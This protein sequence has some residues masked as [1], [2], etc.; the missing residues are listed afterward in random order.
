MNYRES[1]LIL[2]KIKKAER[3][4]VN[5]H[6]SPDPDSVGSALSLY[7]ALKKMDKEVEVVCPDALASELLFLPNSKLVKQVNFEKFDYTPFDL[8]IVLD[9]G[10]WDMVTKVREIPLPEIDLIVIDH[11]KTNTRFGKLNL[12]DSEKGSVAE[13]LYLVFED[14][15]ILIDKNIATTLLAGILGDTVV[16]KYAT[17]QALKITAD[18]IAKGAPKDEII[19]NLFSSRDFAELKLWGEFLQKMQIDKEHKFIWSAVDSEIAGNYPKL[20]GN[21]TAATLFGQLVKDIN[22]SIFMFEEKKGR[23]EIS[24]RGRGSF[25]ISGLAER[26]GGG[27]H[28]A[29]AGATIEGLDFEKAVEKVLQVARE[30]AKHEK[31]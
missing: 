27:G 8:F 31:N 15:D 16:L 17:S 3:I 20:D 9:S 11:H 24:L 19:L 21:S 30:F 22:F 18:L 2:E 5:C 6:R 4:L 13:L 12:I 26:L 10:S 29:A 25:D 1:K 7:Q 23:L 14:W 28:K